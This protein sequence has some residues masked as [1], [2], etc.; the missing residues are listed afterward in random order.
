M[1]II[2]RFRR[3]FS[4]ARDK[5][6]IKPEELRLTSSLLNYARSKVLRAPDVTDGGDGGGGGG[7]D[8]IAAAMAARN[9]P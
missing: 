3:R 2:L 9:R 6:S 7:T 1:A 5:H 8:G 4:L